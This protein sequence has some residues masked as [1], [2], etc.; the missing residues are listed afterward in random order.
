MRDRTMDMLVVAAALAAPGVAPIVE[1]G[2][3][4]STTNAPS[5]TGI[6]KKPHQGSRERERRL[7]QIEKI[8]GGV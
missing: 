8:K 6:L 5:R 1:R 7:R 2:I 3:P 4:R